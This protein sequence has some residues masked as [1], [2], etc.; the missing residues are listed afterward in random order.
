M[1]PPSPDTPDRV[2]L[3]LVP[4]TR[5]A[6]NAY[7]GEHHRHHGKVVGDLFRVGI[8]CGERLVG[9]A[10][11]GRPVSRIIQRD[12]PQ[13]CELVRLCVGEGAPGNT[14]RTLHGAVLRAAWALGYT[15]VI[16][17][18]LKTESGNSMRDAGYRVLGE[19]KG[20]SWNTRSRPRTD[21]HVIADRML[22]EASARECRILPASV[23]GEAVMA[24]LRA[25]MREKRDA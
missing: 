5:R 8:R 24:R 9:C 13:I 22:W 16:T 1:T 7:I 4:L 25:K 18:T 21:K 15:R 3:V 6:A 17:Y 14:L 10:V 19:R 2:R 11:V 20:R 23:A 12:E